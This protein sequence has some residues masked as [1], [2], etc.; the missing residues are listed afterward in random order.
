MNILL[1]ITLSAL[2]GLLPMMI[3]ACVLT[4]FDRYERE[5]L[6]LMAAVFL[7]GA[8][9]AAGSAFVLNTIFGI[10]VFAFT[11]DE[12]LANFG[13]AVIS[14]PIVEEAVKGLAVLAVFLFFR[15]E[16]DSLMD[17]IIYGSLV[18]FGFAATE[19]VNY[20]FFSGFAEGGLSGAVMVTLVRAVGIAFLHASLSAC[21]GLGLAYFRLSRGGAR[22]LAPFIG[23]CAAVGFH[24][25]HNFL[26][27]LGEPL[28]CLLGLML[29]WTGFLVLFAFILYLMWR[30]SHIMRDFLRDEAARGLI[31]PQQY[32]TAQSLTGQFM[33][34]WGTLVGG[35]WQ[36]TGQFYD[37][38]GELAFK[39]YH[40]ARRGTDKEPQT[41]ALIEQLRQQITQ[42][43][44]DV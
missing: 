5:P 32:Q 36:Q 44:A 37:A 21:V 17:G 23:Y 31:T 20:I 11:N 6:W 8:I 2:L 43:G 22:Y 15:H 40:L 39:K 7:W 10:A 14:A 41:P 16:F 3:Y 25:A 29:D 33:A 13:A 35:K 34:R 18:G 30:E 28:L 24:A 4:W 42:L 38:L 9:V 1:S 26:A 12:L 27:S 19:N